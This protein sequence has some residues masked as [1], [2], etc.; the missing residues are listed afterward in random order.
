MAPK[1]IITKKD[2]P[3]LDF[4]HVKDLYTKKIK[5]TVIPRDTQVGYEEC[6]STLTVKGPIIS[7]CAE[8]TSIFFGNVFVSGTFF[9]SGN[10]NLTGSGG[11]GGE[12]LA[13]TLV[14]GRWTDGLDLTVS[15]GDDI[16][17]SGGVIYAAA[18]PVGVDLTL[19]AGVGL[20]SVGGHINIDA[21]EGVSGKGGNVYITP[22]V[23]STSGSEIYLRQLDY[24]YPV[25]TLHS[26]IS[27]S[28]GGFGG[29]GNV[30]TSSFYLQQFKAEGYRPAAGHVSSKNIGVG[31]F[32]IEAGAD[33]D[34]SAPTSSFGYAGD[35]PSISISRLISG[36]GG[37]EVAQNWELSQ[38]RTVGKYFYPPGYPEF[39]M[40]AGSS[41]SH[42]GSLCLLNGLFPKVQDR[43]FKFAWGFV[44]INIQ[45]VSI[46]LVPEGV[47]SR[48]IRAYIMF[49]EVYGVVS[50]QLTYEYLGLPITSGE[51]STFDTRLVFM[52]GHE[53][54]LVVTGSSNYATQFV[55]SFSTS[56][57]AGPMTWTRAGF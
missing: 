43:D 53:L 55:A 50:S 36:S 47:Y 49:Q 52:N 27:G 2:I 40:V 5:K 38:C 26:D 54:H 18:A 4:W 46:N 25:F 35:Y 34:G 21:G 37:G 45:G 32:Y 33:G 8:A 48:K 39:A 22:G 51:G 42:S 12:S 9:V 15:S 41:T 6:D 29:G 44:D 20:A 17:M 3:S 10:T 28:P 31:N 23:G 13:E 19:A 14:I 16:V 56:D 11:G 7:D 30:Q 1:T 24:E 57:V